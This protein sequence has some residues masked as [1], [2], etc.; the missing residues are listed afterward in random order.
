[1]DSS[2]NV[3]GKNEGDTSRCR[4]VPS[5]EIEG[6]RLS[7]ENQAC[8]NLCLLCVKAVDCAFASSAATPISSLGK[9]PLS[10][11]PS[12]RWHRVRALY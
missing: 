4:G 2:N 11:R 10:L 1:M 8:E 7:I 5:A 6:L 3:A 12:L 9:A